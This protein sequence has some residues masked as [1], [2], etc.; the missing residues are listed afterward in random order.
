MKTITEIKSDIAKEIGE[1]NGFDFQVEI[2]AEAGAYERVR[3]LYSQLVE[4]Y[5]NQYKEMNGDDTLNK[6]DVSGL[7]PLVYGDTVKCSNSKDYREFWIGKYIGKH[8]TKNRHLVLLRAR[9]SLRIK[10]EPQIF[11][12][13][14]RKLSIPTQQNNQ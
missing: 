1:P 2:E 14:Q 12:Y 11:A 13:C 5:I 10:E 9:P 8:P 4:R 3:W 7:L 6:G